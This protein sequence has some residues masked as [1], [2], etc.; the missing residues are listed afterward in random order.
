MTE[1]EPTAMSDPVVMEPSRADAR[2]G[3][4]CKEDGAASLDDRIAD[5]TK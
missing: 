4:A 5:M 2:L 3:S 1:C